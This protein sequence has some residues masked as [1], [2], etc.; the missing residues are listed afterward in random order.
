MDGMIT[1]G[2]SAY[3]IPNLGLTPSGVAVVVRQWCG[4][5]AMALLR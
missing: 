5:I 4:F 1:A 2:N 3:N